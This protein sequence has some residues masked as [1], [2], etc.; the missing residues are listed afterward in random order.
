MENNRPRV[1]IGMV[2]YF[3]IPSYLLDM[4][5]IPDR[6]GKLEEKKV[7]TVRVAVAVT[8]TEQ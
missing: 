6:H 4:Y 1:G 2:S 5:Y 8:V 7:V 3:S